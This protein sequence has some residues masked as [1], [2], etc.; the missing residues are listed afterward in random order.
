MDL[1]EFLDRFD[2]RDWQEAEDG[3]VRLAMVGI[4][5][6]T[7]EHAIPAVASSDR[8]ETTVAVSSSREKAERAIEDVETGE[9]GITY[10]EFH[11]GAAADRYDAV[12]VS[13]PNARHLPYVETAA[14]LGKHVLCEKPM[15]ASA[16]RARAMV[17]AAADG[18]VRL[19]VGYR[20]QT[21]PAVRRARDLV[22]AGFVGDPVHV[23]G[24][25]TQ[26]LLEMNDDPDQWRLDPD[27]AGPG[28]SVTDLGIYPL[29]TARFVLGADP[30]AVTATMASPSEAFDR[31]PDERATFDVRF[32]DGTLA[33]CAASQNAH[34]SGRFEVIGVEGT[35][36]LQPAFFA[37]DRRTL[38]VERDGTAAE[39]AFETVDQM[40]EEFDY[41]ADRLL[42]GRS[43]EPN[44][45]HGLVDVRTIE[46]V[47]EAAE[48]GSRVSP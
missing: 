28:T 40:T 5:W 42:T 39:F 17:D 31:V 32:E 2:R 35:L 18:D 9:R 14:D 24:H 44:G 4:G 10:D 27:L 16:D 11:D 48:T 15:E 13:T 45:E 22:D 47:Y 19:M 23:V 3:T 41:F 29:N 43:V 46:A 38:V 26:R 33:S 21:E 20:M 36:A 34:D 37:D 8:C 12:Y 6:W 1:Q 25:M 30:T 7:R